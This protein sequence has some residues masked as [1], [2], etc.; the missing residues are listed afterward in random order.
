MAITSTQSTSD[1][2][3]YRASGS[4]ITTDTAADV[5]LTLGFTPK[6]VVWENVTDRIKYE[7]FEGTANGTTVK[8]VAAGT[9]TL[10]TTDVAIS[11]TGGV[12]TI[13]AAVAIQNKQ[14]RWIATA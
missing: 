6:Y 7:W 10:D 13:T 3:V 11:V 8:T 12:V 2:I 4:F 14:C 9:R 1:G 5:T